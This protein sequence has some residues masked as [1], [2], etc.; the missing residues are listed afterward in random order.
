MSKKRGLI[1]KQSNCAFPL[2]LLFLIFRVCS[3]SSATGWCEDALQKDKTVVLESSQAGTVQTSLY[4]EALKA[5]QKGDFSK[6]ITTLRLALDSGS[7]SVGMLTLLGWSYYKSS[8]YES[9]EQSFSQALEIDARVDD[10]TIGLAYVNLDNG[11]PQV[12]LSLFL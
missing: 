2:T 3:L 4:D 7:K 9:A 12:A 1:S 10:A 5:Y 6:A 8:Q 11:H